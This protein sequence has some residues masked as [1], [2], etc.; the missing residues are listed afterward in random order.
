MSL[1]VK[2]AVGGM[3]IAAATAYL[4]YLGAS[5]SY[6]YYVLVDE[7][8]QNQAELQGQRLRVAG[9]VAPNSLIIRSDR[10]AATFSLLGST[11]EVRVSCP[12][13][14][15]DNLAED[16]E[17][18]VEGSLAD[19][20]ELRLNGDKVLTRCASKYE[21]EPLAERRESHSTEARR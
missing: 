7:C 19:D 6:R 15:P 4:A 9:R 17:V 20:G 1:N 8:L 16:M 5:S 11:G 12:G 21:A 13:P 10:M 2:L 14:L 3:I 18:V